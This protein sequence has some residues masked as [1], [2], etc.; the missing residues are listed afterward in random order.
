MERRVAVRAIVVHKGQLLC[1]RLK[2]Y[3]NEGDRATFWS[4][5]GGGLDAEEDLVSGLVR[6]MLEETGI[7]P[8]VGA[9][10]YIQQYVDSSRE[11]LEFFFHV[12]NAADYVNIDLSATSHGTIEIEEIAFIN[13]HMADVPVLPLFLKNVDLEADSMSGRTQYFNNI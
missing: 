6:E 11:Y 2:S 8:D 12:Q 4:T 10:L 1:A 9:L 13:P 7:R 3:K 5:P